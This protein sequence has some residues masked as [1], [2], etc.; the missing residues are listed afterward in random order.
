MRG[1]MEMTFHFLNSEGGVSELY[2]MK[3]RHK[4]K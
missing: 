4:C 2:L 1:L 3:R